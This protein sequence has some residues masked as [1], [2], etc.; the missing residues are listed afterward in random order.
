MARNP[1]CA[2]GASSRS[3]RSRPVA[4][5]ATASLLVAAGLGAP[6]HAAGPGDQGFSAT[7]INRSIV[8]VDVE[9]T[10]VVTAVFPDGTVTEDPAT[11]FM[12]CTGWFASDKGHVAT[13]G[14]C[15]EE[16]ELI[17]E[18]MLDSVMAGSGLTA[19]D[20]DVMGVRW[21]H[22]VDDKRARVGQP[23]GVEGG[24]LSGDEPIVAEIIGF[25]GFDDGDNGLLKIANMDGT[26]ALPIAGERPEIGEEVTAIGFPGEVSAVTDVKRQSSSYKGGEV[27]SHGVSLNGAPITEIDA[28]VSGGMSGGPTLNEAGEVIGMNSFKAVG[29]S[30]TSNFVTDTETMRTF[31]EGE[32]VDLTAAPA[33]TGQDL[34]PAPSPGP[35]PVP[36]SETGGAS[37]RPLLIA[38]L[39][40]AGTVL[41]GGLGTLLF[42]GVQQH[43]RKAS[44][45]QP[46]HL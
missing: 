17:G 16:D 22:R 4:K 44:L 46:A 40:V 41:V 38:G 30:D 13:A 33:A 19:E 31:L 28:S 35:A 18:A 14:H 5:L 26:P 32:G 34:A 36:A 11:V 3:S 12:L 1:R 23:S 10:G 39:S 15:L 9:Y 20:L 7:E 21:T 43:R 24:P 6:A 2:A 8:W 29:E 42:R 27:S 25:Q 45:Q 37:S